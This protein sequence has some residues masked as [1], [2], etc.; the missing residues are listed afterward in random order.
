MRGTDRVEST[1][2]LLAFVVCLVAI[3]VAIAE[4]VE[5]YTTAAGRIRSENASRVPVTATITREPS[6]MRRLSVAEVR[7][8]HDSV[9]GSA[10]IV[11]PHSSARGNLVPLWLGAD[12][13]PT[14][15]PTRPARAVMIGLGAATLVLFEIWAAAL[16]VVGATR[17]SVSRY[18]QRLWENHWKQFDRGA[19]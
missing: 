5:E 15:A 9:P 17:C 18:H 13:T 12:A 2:R 6:R 16:L 3:P 4:G 11:V 1:I 19:L 7:W 10:T 8:T 14:T